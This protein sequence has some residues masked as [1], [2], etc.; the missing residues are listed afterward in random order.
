[1][2]ANWVARKN[3]RGKEV[4]SSVRILE[5][6]GYNL[7]RAMKKQVSDGCMCT[8]FYAG[9][10]ISTACFGGVEMGCV[11]IVDGLSV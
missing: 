2:C 7:K 11:L 10:M 6:C 9:V 5:A 4:R 3:H 8:M 1:V